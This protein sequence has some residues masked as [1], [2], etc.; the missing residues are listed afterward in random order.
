[1]D[2]NVKYRTFR[3]KKRKSGSSVRKNLLGL[4]PKAQFVEEKNG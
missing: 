3:G 4:T 2:L 1:M